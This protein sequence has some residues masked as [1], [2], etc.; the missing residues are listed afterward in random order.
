MKPTFIILR[1][2]MSGGTGTLSIRLG[3]NLIE[4]GY[5]VI[6]IYQEEN[7]L[8]NARIMEENGIKIYLWELKNIYKKLTEVFGI[9]QNYYFLTYSLS[10]F[11]FV[12][13]L[14]NKLKI[15]KS[16]LYI[17]YNY[18]LNKGM[19]KNIV[20]KN[21]IKKLY[22][23]IITDLLDNNSII[24]MDSI[25]IEET[26]K[27]YNVNIKNKED[28]IFNLPYE[29]RP[30]NINT[31]NNKL[32]LK[33]FNLLTIARAEFP[34]KGYMIGLLD[35]FKKLCDIYS[36]MTLT[37]I[38]S[39]ENIDKIY[40]KISEF[41][42]NIKCKIRVFE[43][44]PYD[45]LGEYFNEAHLYLGMGTTILDSTNNGVPALIVQHYTYENYSA[46]FF[47]TQPNLLGC[48]ADVDTPTHIYIKQVKH[49]SDDE[50]LELCIKEYSALI[51]NYNIESLINYLIDYNSRS[52]K[53]LD[54]L[55][56][57]MNKFFENILNIVRKIIKK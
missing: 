21:I 24:F 33:T 41:P 40:K 55:L 36:D 29:T 54:S 15:E 8:N 27:Y 1:S 16:T 13:S 46:G 37:V 45:M 43:Q 31:I 23:K 50:Y 47:H 22:Y 18:E 17:V 9:E 11:L 7:D 25:S 39:G 38:T 35:D 49:M 2:G 53:K 56:L 20:I 48:K 51:E 10:E 28:R 30:L 3:K 44:V 4:N 12:E 57:M 32:K 34:F 42:D 5:T 26:E 14:K 19:N 52:V 6:Y